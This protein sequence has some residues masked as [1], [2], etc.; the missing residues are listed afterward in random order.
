MAQ[1][2]RFSVFRTDPAED[3]IGAILT[4]AAIFAN[5]DMIGA[6]GEMPHLVSSLEI[7]S[8]QQLAW[9]LWFFSRETTS[10]PAA[11]ADDY[12]RGR[13]SFQAADGVQIGATGLYH[14]S[15]DGLLIP[16]ECEDYRLHPK[17]HG[18]FHVALV[19]RSPTAKL[20]GPTGA[21]E[22]NFVVQL[23]LGW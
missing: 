15:I 10:I 21:I 8:V 2:G 3:F 19:N 12:F 22:I 11:P 18:Q 4:N 5:L 9:E 16:N 13:W 1:P 20:A 17:K 7:V 14:Y 6:V 23:G